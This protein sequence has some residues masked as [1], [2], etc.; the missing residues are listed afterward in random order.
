[1]K[2]SSVSGLRRMW[3][4]FC[5]C[6]K[7]NK[8][9]AKPQHNTLLSTEEVRT[10]KNV[11]ELTRKR[12]LSYLRPIAELGEVSPSQKGS[13]SGKKKSIEGL[14]IYLWTHFPDLNL[15]GLQRQYSLLRHCPTHEDFKKQQRLGIGHVNQLTRGT[16]LEERHPTQHKGTRRH[17]LQF[18]KAAT[19][20]CGTARQSEIAESSRG[21]ILHSQGFPQAST[22][23][24]TGGRPGGMTE[25][26]PNR[27]KIQSKNYAS[28]KQSKCYLDKNSRWLP[29]KTKKTKK[30]KQNP[31]KPK[32]KTQNLTGNHKG[33][34]VRMMS[35]SRVIKGRSQNSL[36][37]RFFI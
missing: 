25:L 26:W 19:A 24:K 35:L 20:K 16:E 21:G 34:K 6:W 1:M 31:K 3:K 37:C 15:E 22:H 8:S 28:K 11:K 30:K 10:H 14:W 18:L 12:P 23:D 32:P 29:Y 4:T 13:L 27:S 36:V 2:A 5:S 17:W 9:P 7:H 33:E